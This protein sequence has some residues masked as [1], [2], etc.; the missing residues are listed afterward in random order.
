MDSANAVAGKLGS[1][2]GVYDKDN[3]WQS[4]LSATLGRNSAWTFTLDYEVTTSKMQADTNSFH[5][6][7]PRITNGWAS[8]YFTLSALEG[9]QITLWFGQRQERVV[10]SG[11]N[12]R[13]EPAF[14]GA[15]LI[16][17]THF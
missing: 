11:G 3:P 13:L 17:I 14:E 12:C 1:V 10:C 15:E 5:Y 6:K 7:L 4:V 9:N 16:W 8:A 2:G